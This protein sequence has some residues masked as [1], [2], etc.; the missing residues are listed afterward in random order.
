MRALATG[1][2]GFIGS[3]LVRHLVLEAGWLVTTI[4]RLTYAAHRS[5]LGAEGLFSETTADDPRSP[6]SASKAASDNLVSAWFHT[7]GLP[8]CIS[9]CSNNYGPY[10]L[11]EKLI[12]FVTDRPGHE[13]RY[14][15]DPTRIMTEPGWRPQWS[16]EAGLAATVDRYL[17]NPGWWQPL[18]AG[19]H[20]TA[21]H[22]RGTGTATV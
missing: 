11:P 4:D 20:G 10:Q 17:A 5:S 16:F 14:A 18:W 15:I 19:G 21:R 7:H 1:G 13:A 2:A 3:A 8:V 6:D 22:G 9:N 12:R